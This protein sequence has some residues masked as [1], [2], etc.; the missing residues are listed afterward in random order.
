VE[1]LPDNL[2]E[3]A[4]AED[5]PAFHRSVHDAKRAAIVEAW[6]K[7]RGDYKA[8]AQILGVHPNSLLRMVRNLGLR[9]ELEA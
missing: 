3:L 1:D 5:A 4:P 8:A 7:G 2:L 6:R 9:T